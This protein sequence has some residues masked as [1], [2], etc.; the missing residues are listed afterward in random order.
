MA[1]DLLF[2]IGTEEIPAG[3]MK[4]ALSDLSELAD[5][6]LGEARIKYEEI[7]TYGT[8]RRLT[9]F[10]KALEERQEDIEEEVKGPSKKVAFDADGNPTKA[11]IGFAK[12][13]G[14]SPEEL[15][16][17]ELKGTEY[18]YALK[19][20]SGQATEAIL[21]ELLPDIVTS[22]SFPKTMRW[23]DLDFKFVRPI[24]WLIALYGSERIGFE[25]AGIKTDYY[26]RGHRFLSKEPIEIS[27]PKDYFA[28]LKDEYVIADQRER[29]EII[30]EQIDKLAASHGGRIQEDEELLE[31]INYLVEYPTA[32]CGSFDESYL[33]LPK[34]VLITPMKEHQRYY[35]VLNEQGELMNKFITV[36]NGNSDYL[37]VVQRGNEKVLEARLADAKFFYDEDLK[38]KLEDQVKKLENVTFHEDIGTV[39]EKLNRMIDL[40][41]YLAEKIGADKETKNTADR[42]A[43]LAKGDLV[44]NMVYEFPEL[45]G[46]MGAYYAKAHGESEEVCNGIREHYLPKSADDELPKTDAGWLVSFADKLDT[47]VDC[48]A[49]GIQPTGSQDP[50]ALRRQSLAIIHLILDREVHLNLDEILTDAYDRLAK[51]IKPKIERPELVKVMTEFFYQRMRSVLDDKNHRYD[52]V[53]AV[54]ASGNKDLLAIAKWADAL[55]SFRED[56]QFQKLL[57]GFN[58]VANLA[59]KGNEVQVAENLLTEDAEIKLYQQFV[60]A[61]ERANQLLEKG[62]LVSVL[63]ELAGLQPVIDSFFEDIMVM[64]EDEKI[65]NN[66]LALLENIKGFVVSM[67]D[68]TKIVESK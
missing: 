23:G 4:R 20:E 33:R 3:F 9:L 16:T 8:P 12:S 56:E 15:T 22:M 52:V 46:I 29:K 35:P 65:K 43:R 67:V 41:S 17:K 10:I 64:V 50:Y 19:K 54:L 51:D 38:T 68:L 37:D 36:R 66:R 25:L 48:F 27:E 32:L 62:E 34:E 49:I 6:K 55:S 47:I 59:K 30:R 13:Q 57:I 5:K 63:K 45:Q 42:V 14:V 58:R 1:K 61:R 11:A 26:T 18:I 40:T 2:E 24:H 53:D 39:K 44:T 7:N 31:E 28:S 21:T 60:A